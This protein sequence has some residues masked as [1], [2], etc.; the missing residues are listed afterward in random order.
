LIVSL[1]DVRRIAAFNGLQSGPGSQVER[2]RHSNSD[3]PG[4]CRAVFDQEVAFDGGWTQF[5]SVTYNGDTYSGVGQTQVRGV[6]E[7]IQAVGIYP[8]HGTA[9]AVFDRLVQEL[10]ACTALHA[11]NYDFAINMADPTTAVLNSSLWKIIYRVKS[12]VLINVAALG[13]PQSEETAQTI[14]R[15]ITDRVE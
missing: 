3:A 8:D 7:A 1:D 13:L 2:P 6:A 14:L 5:H 15:T 11:D 9:H 12:S 10:T 4:P